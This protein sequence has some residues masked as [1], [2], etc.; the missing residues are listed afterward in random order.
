M[1]I[2][3]WCLHC[4]IKFTTLG[5]L[6]AWKIT[7]SI[8]LWIIM[9]CR[10]SLHWHHPGSSNVFLIIKRIRDSFDKFKVFILQQLIIHGQMRGIDPYN[11][12]GCSIYHIF[13]LF[14]IHGLQPLDPTIRHEKGRWVRGSKSGF[15][16]HFSSNNR[17]CTVNKEPS[18]VKDHPKI[19]LKRRVF[20]TPF[21]HRWCCD[22]WCLSHPSGSSPPVL[23]HCQRWASHHILKWCTSY[24]PENMKS[25]IFCCSPV[26][27]EF[28]YASWQTPPRGCWDN[29][30]I[31]L[32]AIHMVLLDIPFHN[33][34]TPSGYVYI[35]C[36]NVAAPLLKR[37]YFYT[38]TY[39]IT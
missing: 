5:W 28:N 2:Y 16:L 37:A 34:L 33:F 17:T 20:K 15:I 12:V 14:E 9:T 6:N 27:F 38:L 13:T 18:C 19:F 26:W 21:Y 7:P 29:L 3:L 30:D 36:K 8:L 39:T 22:V 4:K 11:V 35:T 1:L 31:C 25:K 23:S 32:L 10:M 24:F